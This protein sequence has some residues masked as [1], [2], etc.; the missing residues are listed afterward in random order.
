[1]SFNLLI[2]NNSIT[3]R[4]NSLFL[5][6]SLLRLVGIPAAVRSPATGMPVAS[7]WDVKSPVAIIF[8]AFALLP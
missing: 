2:K 3:F 7:R 1:M 6:P 5:C 4:F 8:L